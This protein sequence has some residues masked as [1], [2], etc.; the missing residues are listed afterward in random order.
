MSVVRYDQGS[1]PE[2]AEL[3]PEGFLRVDAPIT[4]LGVLQ[5]RNADGTPRGELRHPDDWNDFVA[6]A[7][8]PITNDHPP[9]RKSDGLQLVDA[10]NAK[11]LA[12]G[13]T[14]D[15]VRADGP[16]LRSLLMITDAAG[17]AAVQR[18]RR[19]TST[20]V[21]VDLKQESGEYEGLRYEYRQTNPRLNH[22]AIVDA[23][24]AGTMIRLDGNQLVDDEAEGDRNMVKVTLDGIAYEAAP[25]VANALTR[26][27]TSLAEMSTKLDSA[28]KTA[29]DAL[30]KIKA[31]RD[32]LKEKL[33]AAEKRD[34]RAEIAARVLLE[35]AARKVLPA[36]EHAKLDA[37]SDAEVRKAVA[38]AKFPKRNLDDKPEAYIAA[39]FDQAVEEHSAEIANDRAHDEALSK[40]REQIVPRADSGGSST[41]E[42]AARKASER[43]AN[44]WKPKAA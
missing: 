13:W 2:K 16:L 30:E 3:T 41:I 40:Q 14:G 21:V 15:S 27:Q 33:D 20:G 43:I 28:S 11:Q 37:M 44:Q 29:S 22:V 31:E 19:G 36:S 42:D 1:W 18:G 9:P 17:V 8:K 10:K 32:T 7:S 5:Y 6:L 12:I 23:P 38:V 24:R 26:A 34:I 25:E 39:C 35:T 4:R